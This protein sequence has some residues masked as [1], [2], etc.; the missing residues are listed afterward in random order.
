MGVTDVIVTVFYNVWMICFWQIT[1]TMLLWQ[2]LLPMWQMLLPLVDLMCTWLMLLPK[3][4]LMLLPTIYGWCYCH[5]WLMLLP[6]LIVIVL[7]DVIANVMADVFTICG[8]WN[9]H[10]ICDGLML[11]PCGRWYSHLVGM[12]ADVIWPDGMSHWVNYFSFS[13][14]LLLRTSSHIWGRWYLPMFLFRDGPL[15]LMYMD[16][17]ISLERLCS[18]LPTTL[19]LSSVVVWPEVLLWSCMGEWAFRCSL[20]LSPNVLDVSPMYSSSHSNLSHLNL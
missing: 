4:W 5:V 2:I 3:C 12:W 11:L 1:I 18:S 13:S 10:F 9:S 16:S 6:K 8:R 19:K 20:N 15:T 14:L 7:A 17:L